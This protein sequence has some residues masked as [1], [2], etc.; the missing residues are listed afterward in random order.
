MCICICVHSLRYIS[1]YEYARVHSCMHA[2][3]Y[4][5]IYGPCMYPHKYMHV[6]EYIYVCAYTC[7]FVF[8]F[9][10]VCVYYWCVCVHTHTHTHC[11]CYRVTHTLC[12]HTLCIHTVFVE[13]EIQDTFALLQRVRARVQIHRADTC[14]YTVVDNLFVLVCVCTRRF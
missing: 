7:V 13:R 11:K 9:V 14:M 5:C 1:L 6:C 10:C 3:I 2:Y 12:I 8:V 4:K